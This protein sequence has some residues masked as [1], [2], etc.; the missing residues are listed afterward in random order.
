MVGNH[1]HFTPEHTDELPANSKVMEKPM[2]SHDAEDLFSSTLGGEGGG[3]WG[4]GGSPRP[5]TE[6]L[7]GLYQEY[8]TTTVHIIV[9]IF[10]KND[11]TDF[12]LVL[13]DFLVNYTRDFGGA[14]VGFCGAGK[15]MSS[16]AAG[17]SFFDTSGE[18][19]NQKILWMPGIVA[20]W[21]GAK[22][23]FPGF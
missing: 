2:S 10:G 13:W 14:A 4:Q 12:C 5:S 22:T 1:V 3:G 7:S 23:R 16:R 9:Y 18:V 20:S 19:Q 8:T 11:E 21:Q 17:E 6:V 15:P